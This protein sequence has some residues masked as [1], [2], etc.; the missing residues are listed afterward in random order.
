MLLSPS[1]VPPAPLLPGGVS[2]LDAR[3]LL[4]PLL[5][6]LGFYLLANASGQRFGRPRPDLRQELRRLNVNTLDDGQRW[7]EREEREQTP[8]FST[9]WLDALLRP[10]LSD[11]GGFARAGLGR[12]G[13]EGGRDL[14]ARLA[15]LDRESPV[16]DLV[17][18]FWSKKTGFA[19]VPPA[20]LLLVRFL[21]TEPLDRVPVVVWLILSGVGFW[22]P[23]RRL[24]EQLRERRTQIVLE[25]PA[26]IDQLAIA[27]SAGQAPE[28]ALRLV[29]RDGEGLLAREIAAT[30]REESGS[31]RPLMAALEELAARNGVPELNSLIGQFS[32]SDR[33]GGGDLVP[34]LVR[35]SMLMMEQKRLRMLAEG[36]KARVKMLLPMAI[37]TLPVLIVVLLAPAVLQLAG[38]LR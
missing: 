13:I 9:P 38:L 25:L 14:E 24:A 4:W 16:E 19:L 28:Q 21:G 32:L 17:G 18:R 12:F 2:L 26:L 10:F 22:L 11:L 20:L 31:R 30:M 36:K 1:P 27:I 5:L 8:L 29:A 33:R 7:G 37:C 6:G 15:L 35:Q 3:A 34:V 23:N